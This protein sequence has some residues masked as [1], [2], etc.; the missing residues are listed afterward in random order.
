MN[1]NNINECNYFLKKVIIIY[2]IINILLIYYSYDLKYM[3]KYYI[4]YNKN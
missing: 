1:Y 2:I 3:V 4:K